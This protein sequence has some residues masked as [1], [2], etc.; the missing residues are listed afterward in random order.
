MLDVCT[1]HVMSHNVCSKHRVNINSPSWWQL[2]SPFSCAWTWTQCQ[3][4]RCLFPVL[5]IRSSV[6]KYT[7][8]PWLRLNTSHRCLQW[9]TMWILHCL[10]S[11]WLLQ[12]WKLLTRVCLLDPSRNVPTEDKIQTDNH[13]PIKL[14]TVMRSEYIY[15]VHCLERDF[16]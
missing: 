10:H 2:L 15:I 9:Q 12:L 1:V 6:E 3:S 14:V 7:F 13:S 11:L 5:A 16:F 8:S 4:L